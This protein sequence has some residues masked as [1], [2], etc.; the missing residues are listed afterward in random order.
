MSGLATKYALNICK[1]KGG[2]ARGVLTALAWRSPEKNPSVVYMPQDEICDCTGVVENTV[3]SAIE[4]LVAAHEVKVLKVGGVRPDGKR[5]ATD[6]ELVGVRQWIAAGCPP[7]EEWQGAKAEPLGLKSCTLRP[8][9]LHPSKDV[10]NESLEKQIHEEKPKPPKTTPNE[11]AN[12]QKQNPSL[13][14]FL[15][16]E[17][18]DED[19]ARLTRAMVAQCSGDDEA[20]HEWLRAEFARVGVDT[21]AEWETCTKYRR[22]KKRGAP[23]RADFVG[24]LLNAAVKKQEKGGPVKPPRKKGKPKAAGPDGVEIE[25]A[26]AEAFHAGQ[27]GEGEEAAKEWRRRYVEEWRKRAEA[28]PSGP[29]IV[30]DE[31]QEMKDELE[32]EQAAAGKVIPIAAA[33][34]LA[35][36]S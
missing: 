22:K 26:Y 16:E 15:T 18:S 25:L 34:P 13:L 30:R 12:A 29:K 35:A 21:D 8:Q 9:D 32:R 28:Q 14:S 6:Y 5:E 10:I 27:V 19:R 31:F 3:R 2:S 1:L 24:W 36:A 7:R 33:Q 11:E 17:R 4:K 23:M 20:W